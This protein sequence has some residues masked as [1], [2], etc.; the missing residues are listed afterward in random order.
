MKEITVQRFVQRI[1]LLQKFIRLTIIATVMPY[2]NQTLTYKRH[3]LIF[4]GLLHLMTMKWIITGQEKIPQDPQK[5][6]RKD[7]LKR[8]AVAFQAYYEH[9]PL[10]RT[11]YQIEV[12]CNYTAV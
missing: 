8:R 7:F 1:D 5:Q 11:L 6:S 2:I 9:M 4:L 12:T 10:R 3:M